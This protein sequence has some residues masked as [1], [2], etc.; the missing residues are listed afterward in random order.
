MV[1]HSKC[2][3][4]GEILNTVY[5]KDNPEGIGMVC[6][7]EPECKKRQHKVEHNDT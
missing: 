7:N 4:C 2:K 5:L 1:N 3:K 6:V